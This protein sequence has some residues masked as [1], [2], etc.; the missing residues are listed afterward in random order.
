MDSTSQ[1]SFRLLK[2]IKDP[3]FE[4]DRLDVYSLSLYLGNADFQVLIIDTEINQCVLLEDYVFDSK[5]NDEEKTA[6]IKIIFDD[7]HLLLANFWKSISLIIK[8]KVFSFVPITLFNEDKIDGYLKINA[9]FIPSQEEVMLTNHKQQGFVNVFCV[10]KSIVELTSKIYPGKKINFIHQS[11]TLINGVVAKSKQG[12]KDIVIYIDRFGLHVIIADTKNLVFY[13]QYEINKFDDYIK[14]IKL[15]A[16]EL[17]L[18]LKQERITLYGFLGNNTPH[19]KKLKEALPQLTL[20]NRP[21]NFKF[22]YVFDE[23][24]D[25]QYFD[26]FSTDTLRVQAVS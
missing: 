10:P 5:L 21:D 26:L 18:N 8:N 20:G 11:S 12:Q 24:L 14:F 3:K 19:F 16:N 25:H 4:I 1:K 13:N 9:A 23:V 22:G 6:A 17:N 2:K 7:H 15:V